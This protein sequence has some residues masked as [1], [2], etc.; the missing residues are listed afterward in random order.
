MQHQIS[1]FW[2]GLFCITQYL[3]FTPLDWIFNS[4]SSPGLKMVMEMVFPKERNVV[5]TFSL[6]SGSYSSTNF[7][8]YS[9][10]SETIFE[11]FTHS[12]I[13]SFNSHL[14]DT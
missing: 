6:W 12:L 4:S 2:C 13:L 7:W 14:L 10:G 8:E 5:I 1:M 11:W 9:V 3:N